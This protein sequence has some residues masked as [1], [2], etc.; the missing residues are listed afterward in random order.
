M[1]KNLSVILLAGALAFSSTSLATADLM[2]GLKDTLNKVT[3][4]SSA[5]GGSTTST[6]GLSEITEGLREALKVGTGRV[7]EQISSSGGYESDP[8]IHIPLPEKM[9]QAQAMLRKFG[10]SGLADDVESRLNKGAEAA[11]PKTK[12]LIVK[13]ITDMTV[14]DA[15]K[16][17]DGP[18]DAA[19]QYFQKVATEDL[20][21][22]VRPIIEQAL[23]DA[24]AIAAYNNLLGEYAKYPFVPDIKSDLGEHATDLALEGLFHYLAK[25]E[26][27]IRNNPVARTTEVLRSVFGGR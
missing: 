20:S 7:V 11:A 16:I 5:T 14:E 8:D 13:A 2:K 6:L 18:D 23:E 3:A 19:T 25:E 1:I 27:S 4:P 12:E 15:Q 9:Q 17:Y 21:A 24:G 10:L 22:T 26:A